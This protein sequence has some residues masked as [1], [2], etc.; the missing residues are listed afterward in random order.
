MT[1]TGNLTLTT[2]SYPIRLWYRKGRYDTSGSDSFFGSLVFTG[3]TPIVYSGGGGGGAGDGT[4]GTSGGAGGNYGG[5]GGGSGS[6][7]NSVGGAGAPGIIIITYTPI[8]P[9]D[10]GKSNFFMFF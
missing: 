7:T 4:S 2:G 3:L 9:P 1:H 8:T 5:G 6:A 10:T